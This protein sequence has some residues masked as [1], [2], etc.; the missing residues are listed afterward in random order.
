MIPKRALAISAR[1]F[2]SISSS[3]FLIEGYSSTNFSRDISSPVILKYF[4]PDVATSTI[5]SGRLVLTTEM[6]AAKEQFIKTFTTGIM[7]IPLCVTG[8]SR[9]T[10]LSSIC[11][12]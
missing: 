10:T 8:A 3:D 6:P 9:L 4:V 1:L 7:V 12:S 11:S 2:Y 5:A